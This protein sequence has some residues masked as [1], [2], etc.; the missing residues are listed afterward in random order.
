MGDR[1]ETFTSDA[2]GYVGALDSGIN[3]ASGSVQAVR[4]R[5]R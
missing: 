3:R 2:S 1:T 5:R 4:I